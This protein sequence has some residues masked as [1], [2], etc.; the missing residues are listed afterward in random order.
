MI[1]DKHPCCRSIRK[2]L[3]QICLSFIYFL[4][5]PKGVE[6]FSTMNVYCK[7]WK[8]FVQWVYHLSVLTTCSAIQV[9]REIA[10]PGKNPKLSF[11][12]FKKIT[13]FVVPVFILI[14]HSEECHLHKEGLKN[15][16]L[17]RI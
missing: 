3:R 17:S 11:E 10:F 13:Y 4:D 9:K 14:T 12:C 1:T 6:V 2:E 7:R 15:L 5:K 16:R 8:N